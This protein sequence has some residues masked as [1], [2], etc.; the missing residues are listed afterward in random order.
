[1]ID[2]VFAECV[3]HPDDDGPRLVWADL[4]GG[5]RGELVVVQCD[6]ARAGRQPSH[7]LSPTEMAARRRRERELVEAHGHEWAG[8]L[9]KL[10]TRWSFRRGF[11]ETAKV[12]PLQFDVAKLREHPL[13]ASITLEG[14]RLPPAEDVAQFRAIAMRSPTESIP[15]WRGLRAFSCDHLEPTSLPD[16]WQILK[17]SPI[18]RLHFR[19]H[20]LDTTQIRTLLDA[21]PALTSLEVSP[22]TA[23]DS[24]AWLDRPLRALRVGY[25][26]TLAPV[27]ATRGLESFGFFC[28]PYAPDGM[29]DVLLQIRTLEI[30][31]YVPRAVELLANATLPALRCVR[32][33]GAID[34]AALAPL[35]KRF[36][37]QV[38]HADE[39]IHE[40]PE[41]MFELGG[42][43]ILRSQPVCIVRLDMSVP[44]IHELPAHPV[45]ERVYL[46]R[47][48]D[49]QLRIMSGTVARRHA[50]LIWNDGHHEIRDMGSTNGVIIGT[51]RVDRRVLHDGDEVL[52]GEAILRYF[53][54]PGA[55]DR[56][57]DAITAKR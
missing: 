44:V 37:V 9:A 14:W 28:P 54:G 22:T 7:R 36:D 3:A 2:R 49:V 21:A 30:G 31:G 56:A 47:S 13:L 17:Q 53:V 39:L 35:R 48:S 38:D 55:R 25:V 8:S 10:A 27:A 20:G 33:H 4:V 45:D 24:L 32:L 16:V 6:L 23:P 42:P 46:G 26:D 51:E 11:V 43:Y 57:E 29:L 40:A 19:R 1:M 18:E 15:A 50:M 41:A 12:D 5:E 52:L 34:E